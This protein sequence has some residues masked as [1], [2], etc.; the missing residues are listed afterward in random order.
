[1]HQN[2]NDFQ[3][4]K[5]MW[6]DSIDFISEMEWTQIFGKSIIKGYNYFNA[7]EKSRI[8]NCN[9]LFLKIEKEGKILAIV[10]CFTYKLCLDV[11]APVFVKKISEKLRL[12]YSNFLKIKIFGVGSLASTCEHH[13]GINK[14]ITLNDLLITQEI[15]SRQIKAKSR[16]LKHKLVFIKEV[17][18]SQLQGVK[19]I[20][21]KGFYFYDSLPNCFIPVHDVSPYPSGLKR[22]ERQ[23]YRTLKKEFDSKYTWELIEDFSEQVDQFEKMY[24]ETL[25][26]SE[27]QF[28]K[29][30][31]TFFER[32]NT[33]L[34]ENSFLLA[35]KNKENQIIAAGLVLDDVESLIPLYLGIDHSFNPKEVKLLHANSIFSI[36]EEAEK[37]NKFQ[38]VIGQTSYYPKVLSGALVERLYLGFYSYNP[39][40]QY[41]I[42]KV[43]GSLFMPTKV[44]NN[45]YNDNS[46][47]QIKKKYSS[48]GI[49]IYN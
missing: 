27:N 41:L 15:I 36:I 8:K 3:F 12:I 11:I 14:D 5:Y 6:Y 22:K 2:S 39:V 17:P 24:L 18:D 47:N 23:R 28:E 44:M 48:L 16:E 31:K 20:L 30:N 45:T 7:T 46:S 10:P 1:M 26:R 40:L 21:S 49:K 43:F 4:I 32:L 37:R 34:K 19:N 29:L 35:A 38:V 13:I 25:E 42:K 33:D 9:L